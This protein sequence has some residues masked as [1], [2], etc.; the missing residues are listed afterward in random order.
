MSWPGTT[1]KSQVPL[2]L[3]G[4]PAVTESLEPFAARERGG[5]SCSPWA[6]EVGTTGIC[7][8]LW[9]WASPK[10]AL[11]W[12]GA[13]AGTLTRVL[14]LLAMCPWARGRQ[15]GAAGPEITWSQQKGTP[16]SVSRTCRA[17]RRLGL[18]RCQEGAERWKPWGWDPDPQ[19]A[20][21]PGA[22]SCVCLRD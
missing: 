12:G 8:V 7:C 20:C 13:L 14:L 5:H 15:A 16:G 18:G 21:L 3:P 2:R 1:D 11:C 22:D 19:G 17:P 6:R 10:D 9:S 4:C